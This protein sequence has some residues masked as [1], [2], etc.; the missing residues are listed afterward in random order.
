MTGQPCVKASQL[1]PSFL[2]AAAVGG[3]T[4]C[5]A[6]HMKAVRPSRRPAAAHRVCAC[7]HGPSLR[8]SHLQCSRRGGARGRHRHLCCH[9][10]QAWRQHTGHGQVKLGQPS[11][12]QHRQQPGRVHTRPAQRSKPGGI[13]GPPAGRQR[14]CTGYWKHAHLN[15]RCPTR[16]PLNILWMAL[17]A[18]HALLAPRP[19]KSTHPTFTVCTE[20]ERWAGRHLCPGRLLMRAAAGCSQSIWPGGLG[21]PEH[22]N[23]AH[24]S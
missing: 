2:S 19:H 14:R 22:N 3:S 24:D 18:P 16:G 12:T 10:P 7:R 23:A 15:S 13:D 4:P 9:S 1:P 8:R 6:P 20:M 21:G 17:G 5:T 11:W